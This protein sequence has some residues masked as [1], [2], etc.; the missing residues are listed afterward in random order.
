LTQLENEGLKIYP[1]PKTLKGIQNKGVQK[2]FYAKNNIPTAPFERFENLE[3][4]KSAV[5]SSEVEMPLYGNVL[6]LV[7]TEMV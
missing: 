5:T 2:E 7:M 4:L 3:N 1:S 6:N